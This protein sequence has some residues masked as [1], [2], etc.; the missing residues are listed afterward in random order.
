VSG[1][2]FPAGGGV[3]GPGPRT[4]AL[5]NSR[6]RA[7]TRCRPDTPRAPWKDSRVQNPGQKSTLLQQY[8]KFGAIDG[9]AGLA[10]V[11]LDLQ[12]DPVER[13]L[14]AGWAG[15]WDY[16]APVSRAGTCPNN[17]DRS[18]SR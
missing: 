3:I 11:L 16:R 6:D 17:P 10:E 7:G 9:L 15:F 4:G 2:G 18:A 8:S 1:S 13:G 14:D 12:T 5:A